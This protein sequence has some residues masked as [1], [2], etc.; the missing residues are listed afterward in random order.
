[1]G[2]PEAPAGVPLP[3][4]DEVPPSEDE[5]LA[6]PEPPAGPELL[7]EPE[8]LV[9]LPPDPLDEPVETPAPGPGAVASWVQEADDTRNDAS[10]SD[11]IVEPR[12]MDEPHGTVR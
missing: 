12:C 6:D 11:E 9:G 4:L 2:S 7:D 8:L 3:E 10:A 5:L 1:M